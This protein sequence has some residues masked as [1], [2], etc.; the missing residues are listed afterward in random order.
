MLYFFPRR[1][2]L[3]CMHFLHICMHH[4]FSYKVKIQSYVFANR[5]FHVY[6]MS[7]MS[8]FMPVMSI[9]ACHSILNRQ[10][11]SSLFHAPCC[12]IM[13]LYGIYRYSVAYKS[14]QFYICICF[15]HKKGFLWRIFQSKIPSPLLYICF[16]CF[17]L[18]K[19]LGKR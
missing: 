4:S 7:V 1:I 6:L 17:S 18:C 12:S 11:I 13:G 2:A 8:I 5:H 3:V 9:Y 10:W 16:L 14:A 15:H 19:P